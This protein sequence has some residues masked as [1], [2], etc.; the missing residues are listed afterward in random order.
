MK[1]VLFSSIL[2]LSIDQILKCL[3]VHG[4]KLH[5]GITIISNFFS[6]F[7]VQNTGAAWSILDGNRLFLILTT[8]LALGVIYFYF[9]RNKELSNIESYTYGILIGGILGNLGDRIFRGYVVDYLKFDFFGYHFPVFNFADMCIVL[10]VI[11]IFIML[12]KGEKH[13]N[14]TSSK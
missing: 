10:S 2:C 8:F 9:L 3:V 5:H 7:Y 12:W 1:K 6:I 4:L 11:S 13:A 14:T